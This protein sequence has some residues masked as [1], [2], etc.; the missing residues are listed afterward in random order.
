MTQAT[1]EKKPIAQPKLD[2]VPSSSVSGWQLFLVLFVAYFAVRIPWTLSLPVWEAPDEANHFWV[3]H[4]LV[5][6]L[7]LPTASEVATGGPPAEYAS[8]PQLGYIPNVIV[9]LCSPD[10]LRPLFSRFGSLLIGLI[11]LWA[12]VRVGRLLFS[13]NQVAALALP[14]LIVFHPQLVFVNSYTNTDSTATAVSSLIVLMLVSSF[15]NGLSVMNASIVG[16]LFGLL[17]LCKH[18]G[19][20]LAPAVGCGVVLSCLANGMSVPQ[21]VSRLVAMIMA[22]LA[23]SMWWFVRNYIEFSGDWLG[24]RT[25]YESWA[26]VLE[27]GADGPKHPW[28]AITKMSYWRYIF[29]DYCGLFGYMDRYLVKPIYMIYLAFWGVSVAGACLAFK[30]SNLVGTAMHWLK[31]NGVWVMLLMFPACNL[32]ANVIATSMNVTGPHGRYLFPSEIPIL[33]CI[34]AGLGAIGRRAGSSLIVALVALNAVVVIGAWIAF[35]M[36]SW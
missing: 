17:A 24:T 30:R 19:L 7:R 10:V 15:K 28:P 3:V 31:A 26:Q 27:T 18:T 23:A 16:A 29:F 9:G 6:H 8:L 11:T 25:M 12:S 21:M 20:S 13:T 14:V 36:P 33:A 34:I 32:L 22:V 2:F 1:S 5:E 35:Y 4:F